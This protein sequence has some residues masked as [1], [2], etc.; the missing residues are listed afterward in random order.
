MGPYLQR[1]NVTQ[2]FHGASS[3]PCKDMHTTAHGNCI[4]SGQP[5]ETAGMPISEDREATAAYEHNEMPHGQE[6]DS[7][8]P[9]C[10]QVAP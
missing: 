10:C 6:N 2:H 8:P 1:L 3:H 5:R 4:C 9:L 7:S